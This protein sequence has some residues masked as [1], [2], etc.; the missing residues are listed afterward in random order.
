MEHALVN[1]W[2]CVIMRPIVLLPVSAHKVVLR[3]RMHDIYFMQ[4]RILNRS[5]NPVH[6]TVEYQ[7]S[8]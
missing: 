6:E 4:V 1:V 7:L 2:L 3:Q 8:E 5:I